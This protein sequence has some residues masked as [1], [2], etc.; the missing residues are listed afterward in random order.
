VALLVLEKDTCNIF[1]KFEPIVV[2]LAGSDPNTLVRGAAISLLF[3]KGGSQYK[4]IF[5]NNLYDSSYAVAGNALYAYLQTD[6]E[7]IL[8]VLSSLKS[9]NNFSITSS[10]ADYFIMQGDDTQYPWFEEKLK[11][12]GGSDLWYFIKLF[13]MYLVSASPEVAQQGVEELA[14]I[15][16]NHHQF[17]N[18]L[19]AYQTLQLLSDIDGVPEIIEDLRNNETD[20]RGL[21]YF[22]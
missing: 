21:N 9:E 4:S 14:L 7:D 19:S 18:R 15:G 8:E 6:A 10:M 22:K 20:P 2:H 16:K 3:E 11:L 5:H 17:Y 13:G 12:Y 1:D